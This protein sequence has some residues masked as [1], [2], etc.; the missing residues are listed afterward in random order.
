MSNYALPLLDLIGTVVR[1]VDDSPF[2]QKGQILVKDPAP[3]EKSAIIISDGFVK[4]EKINVVLYF[5]GYSAPPIDQYFKNRKFKDIIDASKKGFVFIAPQLGP[6]SEFLTSAAD[7]IAYVNRM[8]G[9]LA[10]FGPFAS[11]PTIEKMVLAAH[12]GGGS[13]MLSATGWFKDVFPVAE[14]WLLDCLY[15]VG[16]PVGAPRIEHLY[17]PDSRSSDPKVKN[18]PMIPVSSAKSLADWRKS[19]IG[20]V[21]EKWYQLS[22]AGLSA[23]VFWG[24]GGTLTRTANLD[25]LDHLDQTSCNLDLRPEFYKCPTVEKPVLIVPRPSPRAQHDP[26]P[27]TVLAECILDCGFL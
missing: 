14:A 18:S 7:A 23:K 25:L 15:G 17:E 1:R 6:K 13:P 3:L 19:L 27:Q 10:R 2:I 20:T 12:S 4:A 16:D 24:N 9:M 21:E 11:A 26:L 5:H 22:K 8:L